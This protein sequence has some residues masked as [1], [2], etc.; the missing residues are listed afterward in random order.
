MKALHSILSV[1]S[2]LLTAF[3]VTL[4]FW[5]GR[6]GLVFQGGFTGL[7][8]YLAVATLACVLAATVVTLMR[9]KAV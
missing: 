6:P 7:L 4:W 3:T 8:S 1:L 9:N 5:A 2:A